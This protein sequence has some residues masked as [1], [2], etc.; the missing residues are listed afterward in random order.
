M[1]VLAMG[2]LRMTYYYAIGVALTSGYAA[3]SLFASGRIDGMGH[4]RV[5]GAFGICAESLFRMNC[6]R[7]YRNIRGLERDICTGCA[8]RR[9]NRS[10]IPHFSMP[11]IARRDYGPDY[12]Y[13]TSAYSVMAWWDYGYWIV[14]VARRIPVTNPTQ[15][16]AWQPRIFSWRNRSRKRFPYCSNG[17]RGT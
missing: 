17:A 12:R 8:H 13:P 7:A 15:A 16:N 9:P 10:A 5:S 11:D 4:R 6:R 1:F 3:D 2:Q 14:D